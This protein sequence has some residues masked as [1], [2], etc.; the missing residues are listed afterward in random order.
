MLLETVRLE[1]WLWL[2]NYQL[3]ENPSLK[4]TSDIIQDWLEFPN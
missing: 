2:I 1:T 4:I 3:D